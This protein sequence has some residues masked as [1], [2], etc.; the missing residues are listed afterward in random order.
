MATALSHELNQPLTAAANYVNSARRLILS[1]GKPS[2]VDAALDNLQ[3]ASKEIVRTGRIVR[4]L[5]EFVARGTTERRLE[6]IT[7]LIEDASELALAGHHSLGVTV[8]FHFE[9]TTAMVYADQIQI[10]QVLTN[11]M[12]NAVEA[13][14]DTERRELTIATA[15][16]DELMVEISVADTGRGLAPDVAARLFEPFVS[17]K[18]DGMGIGLSICRSIIEAH[19]GKLTSELRCDGGTIFRFTL[20]VYPDYGADDAG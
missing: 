4:K 3:E 7:K 19:G 5:R 18:R 12:R 16:L 14:A 10:Q 1:G 17:T 20:P 9:D 13:M 15:M 6:R 11:L 2:S 8:A